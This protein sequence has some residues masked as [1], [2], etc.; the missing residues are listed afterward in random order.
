MNLKRLWDVV[1]C[2]LLQLHDWQIVE[3]ETE[4]VIRFRLQNPDKGDISWSLSASHD[5]GQIF[6]RWECKREGCDWAKDQIAAFE[7]QVTRENMVRA[8]MGEEKLMRS[9]AGAED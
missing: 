2:E 7:Q 4:F 5:W 3:T 8:A 1:R 6:H 9:L